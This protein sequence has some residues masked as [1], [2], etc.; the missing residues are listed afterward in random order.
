MTTS[1]RTSRSEIEPEIELA[2]LSHP[3]YDHHS[4]DIVPQSEKTPETVSN[5]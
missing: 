2:T 4:T 3:T 5:S 1:E